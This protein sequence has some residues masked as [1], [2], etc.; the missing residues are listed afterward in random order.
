[1]IRVFKDRHSSSYKDELS[2]IQVCSLNHN[3]CFTRYT[4]EKKNHMEENENCKD[5]DKDKKK[6]V[7]KYC[8]NHVCSS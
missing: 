1:M 7:K 3:L 5:K 6:V 2:S 4:G 8:K